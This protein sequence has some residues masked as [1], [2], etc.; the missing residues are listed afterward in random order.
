[1]R[2]R[3]AT[4]LL[5]ELPEEI[6]HAIMDHLGNTQTVNPWSSFRAS[7]GQLV[8]NDAVKLASLHSALRRA[9]QT[10][11][12]LQPEVVLD[13]AS[14]PGGRGRTRSETSAEQTLWRRSDSFAAFRA[15]HPGGAIDTLTFRLALAEVVPD[16]VLYSAKFAI[17]WLPLRSLKRLC[18]ET[19]KTD[20]RASS[21]EVRGA[22]ACGLHAAD[23]SQSLSKIT[24]K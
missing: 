22:T 7:K 12:S 15:A 5:H 10:L 17:D 8:S 20:E 2:C 14:I 4:P 1:M 3:V 13:M 9:L 19:N 11:P 18:I 21:Q 6:L 16:H 23:L 24:P